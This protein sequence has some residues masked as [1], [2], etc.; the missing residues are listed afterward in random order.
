ADTMRAAKQANQEKCKE[1]GIG[2]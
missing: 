1:T 2:H